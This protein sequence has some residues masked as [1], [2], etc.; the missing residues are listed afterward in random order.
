MSA[1]RGAFVRRLLVKRFAWLA[2]LT[3]SRAA[4]AGPLAGST[5]QQREQRQTDVDDDSGAERG[6]FMLPIG[7]VLQS[8]IAYGELKAQKLDVYRPAHGSGAPTMVMV[9]GGGWRRGDKAA[10]RAI[11]NKVT[12]WVGRGW[13]VVSVNYRL[14]PEA[15]PL[16]QADD[17]ARALAHVQSLA[18]TW[19]GDPAKVVLMGHSAGAHLVSL[20]TSDPALATRHGASPWLGT[21]SLDSAAFDIEAIMRSRHLGLYDQAFG[22][23]AVVWR[24]ASPFHRLRGKPVAPM[25]I[26]CSSRRGDS[27]PQG[28]AFAEKAQRHGGRVVVY[29]MDAS[30]SEI[31]EQAGAPG[32]Y[33]AEID[34][35]FHSLG[36]S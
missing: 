6:G 22:Q 13:V 9:H 36:L 29:P 34:S 25:M 15:S 21:V 23:D 8:D 14:L 28:R 26:V 35:F 4:G 12:H 5:R 30:H 3:M 27:C 16:V 2:A 24:E 33:T 19:G 10:P 18:R 11:R 1:A 32:A 31:N 17:L 7:A 20:L